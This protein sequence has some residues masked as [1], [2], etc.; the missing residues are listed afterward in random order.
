MILRDKKGKFIRDKDGIPIKKP[1]IFKYVKAVGWKLDEF[2]IAQISINLTNHLKTPLHLVYHE[3]QKQARKRG[4]RVT[5]SEIVG[6][7]Y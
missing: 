7:I 3:I 2:N 6:V 1:G 4:F 5:G